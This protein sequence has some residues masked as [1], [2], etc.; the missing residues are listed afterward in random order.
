M[1]KEESGMPMWKEWRTTVSQRSLEIIVH[2][3]CT[4]KADRINAGKKVSTQLPH[5]KIWKNRCQPIEEEEEKTNA[6]YIHTT[7][8]LGSCSNNANQENSKQNRNMT[9]YILTWYHSRLRSCGM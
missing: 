5:P 4:V 3:E 7:C 6:T 8:T 9:F 1:I 2:R